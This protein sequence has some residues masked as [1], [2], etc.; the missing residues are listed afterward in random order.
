[1]GFQKCG[2]F[3]GHGSHHKKVPRIFVCDATAFFMLTLFDEKEWV[4]VEKLINIF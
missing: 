1:M 3:I 4:L 2:S